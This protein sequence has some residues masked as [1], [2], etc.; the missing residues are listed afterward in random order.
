MTN[1]EKQIPNLIKDEQYLMDLFQQRIKNIDSQGDKILRIDNH[2]VKKHFDD[3]FFHF[4]LYNNITLKTITGLRKRYIILCISFSGHK[5]QKMYQAL[6]LIYQH[7]FSK[8]D[9]IV[10]KPL[11]YIDE[12]MAAFYIG[13]P[14]DNLLEHIKN[15]YLDLKLIKKIAQGLA[16]FHQI[17]PP[18]NLK[19]K[20]HSFAPVYLDPTNIIHRDYNKNTLLAK[21]VLAQFK[22]LKKLQSTLIKS[23]YFFSHGD[24]HPENVIINRF[25]NNQIIFIDFSEI[26]LAPIY[27]DIASFLQQLQFMT[28]S[29]LSIEE[30]KQIEYTFIATYFNNQKIDQTIMNK[31]NLYKAWTSLKS[32]IYFMIFEDKANRDF[33]EYLLT[34]SEDYLRQ[35][36]I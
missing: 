35:I 31:I 4:V 24:F 15:G 11:W 2:F 1:Q 5:R 12:L 27:Y 32:V 8:G 16:K 18:K 28:S 6:E 7:G 10:P 14:G 17:V 3:K 34:Q 29:Y 26:C 22:K 25:N 9:I 19:L 13:V 21:D 23:N 33:A 30:Y 20:K 36:K